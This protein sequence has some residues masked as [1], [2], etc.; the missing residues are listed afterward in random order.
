MIITAEHNL[1]IANVD[2][3]C[4]VIFGEALN[5]PCWIG[6][7]KISQHEVMRIFMHQHFV[8]RNSISVAANGDSENVLFRREIGADDIFSALRMD[9]LKPASVAHQI[10]GQLSGWFRRDRNAGPELHHA[11]E[12]L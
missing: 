12:H 4:G 10:D 6:T 1:A 7:G 11:V 5:K 2:V 3:R 9:A 8:A